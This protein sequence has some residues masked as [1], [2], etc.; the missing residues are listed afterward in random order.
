MTLFELLYLMPKNTVVAIA[1][2][3]GSG[4]EYIYENDPKMIKRVL[5][6][7]YMGF[8][9]KNIYHKVTDDATCIVLKGNTLIRLPFKTFWFKSE[10]EQYYLKN[11]VEAQ[12][13]PFFL[14]VIFM[15]LLSI[16][17]AMGDQPEYR[18]LHVR[19]TRGLGYVYR[20]TWD[21]RKIDPTYFNRKAGMIYSGNV[22]TTIVIE[23]NEG[24][25]D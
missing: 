8:E 9:V 13:L 11:R 24:G 25:L 22:Y 7:C 6:D 18:Q 23:G 12:P 5:P 21:I 16:L 20:G 2:E 3:D 4:W 1:V 10:F 15:T 14:E 19:T 17:V